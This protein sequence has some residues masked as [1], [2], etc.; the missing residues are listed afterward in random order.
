[1][2]FVFLATEDLEMLL[3][4]LRKGCGFL[5]SWRLASLLPQQT[6]RWFFCTNRIICLKYLS[7]IFISGLKNI[8]KNYILTE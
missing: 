5:F 6:L 1:M 7:I 2:S 8:Q 3:V 4:L